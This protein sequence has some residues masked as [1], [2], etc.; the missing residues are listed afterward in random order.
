MA[1]VMDSTDAP[2]LI[3]HIHKSVAFTPFDV[4]WVPCS[5]RFLVVGTTPR[6]QGAFQV[7]EMQRGEENVVLESEKP[8]GIKC[9]TFGASS[10]EDRHVACGDFAGQLNIWDLER[11]E[12]NLFSAQAHAGIVNCIDGIGG[13]GIGYGAPE[14]VTGG[15][16]G[17]VRVWDPRVPEPVV[18]LE[19]EDETARDCWAVTFGNSFNDDDRSVA[20]GYDNGDVK[21][22]DMRAQAMRWETNVGNGVTSCAF[23][24]KD[25]EMN[26]LIVTT[27][28]SKY[29]LF[30]VRTQHPEEGFSALSER[31]HKATVWLAKHLPQNRD[32]W[33]TGGGNGGLNIYKYHYPTS[34]TTQHK[35]G[36]LAGQMGEVSLSLSLSL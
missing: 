30:D 26:K 2:Q 9:C 5:A 6:N 15:R 31:A 20:M 28:E 12:V 22:Y 1:G 14:I 21:L 7:I 18:S 19:P 36:H 10:I 33:V 34:R 29:K 4:K 32:I 35:D 17:C 11:P 13:M 8:S 27:L 24:R 3:E 25:I 16:D 23:D